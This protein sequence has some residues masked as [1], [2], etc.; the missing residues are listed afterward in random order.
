MVENVPVDIPLSRVV[1][2]EEAVN[3]PEVGLL[4]D[5]QISPFEFLLPFFCSIPDYLNSV[6]WARVGGKPARQSA[7]IRT[8]IHPFEGLKKTRQ[9]GRIIARFACIFDP[10]IIRLSLVIPAESQ[11]KHSCSQ[12][13]QSRQDRNI[14][15]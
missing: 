15:E 7:S 2:E 6:L 1:P 13:S 5:F 12:L 4:I 9:L 14:D 11:K 8:R 3:P 10:Q